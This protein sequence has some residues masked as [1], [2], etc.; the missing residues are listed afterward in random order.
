MPICPPVYCL[1]VAAEADFAS[2]RINIMTV[3]AILRGA[4]LTHNFAR[5]GGFKKGGEDYFYLF[6]VAASG[7]WLHWTGFGRIGLTLLFIPSMEQTPEGAARSGERGRPAA[8]VPWKVGVA[9]PE[10]NPARSVG[11][12]PGRLWGARMEQIGLSVVGVGKG[13]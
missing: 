12:V 9:G 6:A 5:K 4:R 8:Y 11:E 7:E 2:A 10:A 13:P 3:L 1:I